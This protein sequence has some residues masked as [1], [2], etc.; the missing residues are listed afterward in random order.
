[1]KHSC[2]KATVFFLAVAV[3]LVCGWLVVS[4]YQGKEEERQLY[5]NWKNAMLPEV[6]QLVR[7]YAAFEESDSENDLRALIR[8]YDAAYE[9]TKNIFEGGGM[10]NLAHIAG[11]LRK[12]YPVWQKQTFLLALD[13]QNQWLYQGLQEKPPAWMLKRYRSEYNSG[14]RDILDTY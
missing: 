6:Q 9:N 2:R 12:D 5:E 1:M 11:W 14:L 10:I 4:W 8:A 7:L 13:E 3:L